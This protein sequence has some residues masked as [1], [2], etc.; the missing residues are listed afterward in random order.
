MIVIAGFLMICFYLIVV[1][2]KQKKQFWNKK[3]ARELERGQYN[4]AV[5][6]L[7]RKIYHM[8]MRKQRFRKSGLSDRQYL[9]ILTGSF[10]EINRT[11]WEHYMEIVQKAAFSEESIS[12]EEAQF[13][14]NIF[15]ALPEEGIKIQIKNKK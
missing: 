7:N 15:R 14:E 10:P 6:Q 9:E 13:C 5:R 2:P 11:D 1:R 8:V 4:K 12:S 3:L